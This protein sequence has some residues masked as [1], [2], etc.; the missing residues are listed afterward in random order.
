MHARFR[1]QAGDIVFLNNW[2]TFHRRDQFV[3]HADDAQKRLL[4]RVWLSVPNSR[5]V[6]PRYAAS[7]GTTAAGALRGGM[8]PVDPSRVSVTK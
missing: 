3:D 4:L 5:A 2:V 1:Q 6:D 7:Y 8:T